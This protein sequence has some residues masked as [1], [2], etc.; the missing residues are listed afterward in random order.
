M[1]IKNFVPALAVYI[2]NLIDG[3]GSRKKIAHPKIKREAGQL[4]ALLA[5]GGWQV[6][7]SQYSSKFFGNWLILL[8][9]GE[10]EIRLIKDRSF[11]M[12]DASGSQLQT[13]PSLAPGSS[14]SSFPAFQDAIC[15]WLGIPAI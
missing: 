11:Y 7:S 10:D 2:D 1:Q 5:A 15:R 3:G 9:Q 6:H 13:S 8:R 14:Y 4:I 12:L